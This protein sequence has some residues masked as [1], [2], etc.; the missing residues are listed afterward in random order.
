[1]EIMLRS[2]VTFLFL[3]LLTRGMRRR[4]LADLAPFEVILLVVMGDIVQQ[5]VTQEDMSLTG[6]VIGVCTFG[7]WASVCSYLTWR[8][9]RAKTMIEG[10]PIL[11]LRDGEPIEHALATERMPIG[12]LEEAARSEGIDDLAKVKAAILEPSGRISFLQ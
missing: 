5:G 1:M 11:L 7:F 2:T 3:L 10:D 9:D 8:F 6:S 12:E 4:T